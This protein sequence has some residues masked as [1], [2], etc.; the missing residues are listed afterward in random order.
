YKALDD[1]VKKNKTVVKNTELTKEEALK[2]YTAYLDDH[3]G[4]FWLSNGISY[5]TEYRGEEV[6]AYNVLLTNTHEKTLDNDRRQFDVI[7][8][9]YHDTLKKEKTDWDKLY[10][11]YTHLATSIT[12]DTAYMDQTMWSVI[13]NR[14]G[15]C[16]GFARTFQYLALQ[17]GIPCIVVTGFQK[18]AKGRTSSIGHM[19]CMA[20][21]NGK[22]YHFDPTWGLATKEDGVDYA[23]FCRSEKVIKRTHTIDN[24]YHIPSASSDNKSYINCKGWFF[25]KFDEESAIETIGEALDKGEKTI[26]LEFGSKKELQKAVDGLIKNGGL[27][28]IATKLHV[29]TLS[30]R[31]GID[32]LL[33]TLR[34][35]F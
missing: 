29:Q 4:V 18:D 21:V 11:I 32:E 26:I 33:F 6:T 12:Y 13:Y 27:S 16:A 25:S 34:L 30:Y 19:W 1:A 7:M 2:V 15:V 9:Q 24:A 28:P 22:W 3:P 20:K 17:E 23:Y 31:Y 14:V 10:K 5:Q 8:A 35:M